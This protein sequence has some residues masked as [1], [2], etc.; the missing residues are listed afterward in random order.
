M[1]AA[2]AYFSLEAEM[3]IS[4][5]NKVSSVS[6]CISHYLENEGRDR[7][8]LPSLHTQLSS[9]QCWQDLVKPLG[10]LNL[11]PTSHTHLVRGILRWAFLAQVV[12][13]PAINTTRYRTRWSQRLDD[14]PRAAS[15]AESLEFA[16][17]SIELLLT[18]LRSN[19]IRDAVELMIENS[20]VPAEMPL[21]YVSN[22]VS[23]IHRANNVQFIGADLLTRTAKIRNNLLKINNSEMVV[24]KK[25]YDKVKVKSYLTDRVLTGVHKTNREYRWEVSPNS[26][27]FA[28]KRSCMEIENKLVMSVVQMDGFDLN[29]AK[30][31]LNEFHSIEEINSTVC[32]ITFEPLKYSDLSTELLN[33]DHG[34]SSF[35]VGHL[36]PLKA[37]GSHL[38]ENIAWVS[39]DGN[40]IQGDKSLIETREMIMRIYN[41]YLRAG[42]ITP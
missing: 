29:L 12:E 1:H 9:I 22:L 11:S 21:D 31:L 38:A 37:A 34:K 35:Q 15:P 25:L 27:H 26:V 16:A 6:E 41:S 17:T 33:P 18:N 19:E 24:M 30:K 14:D 2:I 3:I 10:E 36:N 23:D 5:M 42:V 28:F 20:Q 7:F 32:P 8:S 13:E 39:N 4:S 40:R